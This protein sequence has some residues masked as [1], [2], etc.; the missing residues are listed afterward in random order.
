[1][2]TESGWGTGWDDCRQNQ[3]ENI[4]ARE[5]RIHRVVRP[6]ARDAMADDGRGESGGEAEAIIAY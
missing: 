6:F 2:K 4:T 5:S 1:M 3:R